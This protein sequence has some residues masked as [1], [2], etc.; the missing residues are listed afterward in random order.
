[1]HIGHH[2]N[3]EAMAQRL[4]VLMHLYPWVQ[5]VMFSELA[6]YGPSLDFAQALPG[7]PL[8]VFQELARKYSIWLLPGSLFEK[9]GDKIYNTAPVIDPQGNIIANYRK[10]FPFAPYEVGVTAGDEFLV[11]DVPEIG[12]FGVSICYDM[13]FPE[14]TRTLVSMGAEVILHPVLTH[15][16]D[17]EVELNI[18]RASG[19]MFQTY[20]FDINGCGIGGNGMS[21]VIDPSGRT[22]HQA[23]ALDELIPIEVDLD[24][25]RRQ[26]VRGMMHLGQPLKSFR[27]RKVDFTIYDRNNWKDSYLESLGELEKPAR[28]YYAD[29]ED[30][31][32]D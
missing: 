20:I 22:L 19:A 30:M 26:R 14:T 29:M 25:V 10:M 23:S 2:D 8:P 4:D 9:Q 28:G 13:W 18:A 32:W 27:D 16:I 24:Q 15:S 21:C 5:M 12:R 7:G 31:G 17:R 3:S 11:F 1:M 6:S